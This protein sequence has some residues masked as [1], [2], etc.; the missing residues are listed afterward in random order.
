MLAK[1]FEPQLV[2]GRVKELLARSRSDR[3]A[4]RAGP[5]P[6]TI[7]QPSPAL[8]ELDDSWAPTLARTSRAVVDGQARRPAQAVR[9]PA[10]RLL[11]PARRGVLDAVADAAVRRRPRRSPIA[12]SDAPA[13]DRLRST[14]LGRDSRPG[15][16]ARR[17]RRGDRRR[18]ASPQPTPESPRLPP[19]DPIA[20][21]RRRASR[22]RRRSDRSVAVEPASPRRSSE[23]APIEDG[24]RRA[25]SERLDGC[26][27]SRLP[28]RL[29]RL[30]RR[31]SRSAVPRI[32]RSAALD[33][34]CRTRRRCRRWPMRLRR[35]S[36]PSR[37]S[38][39]RRR[40]AGW[41][42]RPPSPPRAVV[43]DELIEEVAR[44]VLERLSDT[45]VRDAV[46]DIASKIAERLV[47][48]EIERIKAAS[49]DVVGKITSA[50]PQFCIRSRCPI[51]DVA[52][53]A[54]SR[55]PAASRKARP[56][57]SRSQVDAALGGVGRLPVRSRRA[58]A[59]RSSRST[60]R[61]RPSAARCT[62]ATSSRTRTPTSIARFQRMRGKAVFYPMGWDDNGLPTERRVQ[63]YYGVRCDPS[64]PY[65]ADVRAAGASR[66][67]QPISVSRPNFIELCD[68]LTDGR[69]EGVRA[70]VEVRSACRS[71]GR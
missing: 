57:R 26:R 19:A 43:S 47:R 71:T 31:P 42:R 27:S 68:R 39:R 69:R 35:C 48:E 21:D 40:A 44:R 2:I 6:T 64:L 18:L 20:A 13:P 55:A 7:A 16:P 51:A 36:P 49:R 63:N 60:R 15:R 62:S 41:H 46:A 65:D 8:A 53:A 25:R 29:P 45:V 10:R 12:A 9:T 33:C 23:L 37:A 61:R 34:R 17:R 4:V 54:R 70:A 3:S 30:R 1:P 11:R 58:R 66:R 56:R 52:D 67:K 50:S 24:A 14:Q 38:R 22:C 28:A 32:A 59:P 5:R